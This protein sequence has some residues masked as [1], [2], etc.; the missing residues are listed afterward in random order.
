MKPCIE[1]NVLEELLT[2]LKLEKIEENIFRG[3]S[4]DLGFGGLF[5][6]QVLGQ[7][8]SAAYQ[9]VPSDRKAHSLHAYFLR[10]GNAA[11]PI[12][13]DVDCIRDGQSFTTRRVVAIQ[14]GRA[15]F[16]MS[17]SF[18]LDESGFEHQNDAPEVPGPNGIPSEME[19]A[20]MVAD[21]IP[22]AIRE[23]I[24]CAKPIEIRPIN[25]L[26][27]F[28]PEKR[29]PLRYT[30]F[31]TIDQL[32][33]D[34]AIH[35]YLLAYASDF[36]LVVTSLY[37]HGHS[38]WEPGMKIASLD[39]AMWFHRDFRIDDWMLYAMKSPNACKARGFNNGKI[40]TRQGKLVASV[41]QEG[42]IRYRDVKK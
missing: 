4:Q 17:A 5:G 16:N 36:G 30:W 21:K 28:A 40:Y 35:Q 3:Q 8:L 15:I 41:C 20:E 25:P 32:P 37:P 7:A 27:P 10:M 22:D 23:K 1:G 12:V 18:Q 14:K 31:K 9:T 24:L 42:L 19:L 34:P 29:E 2:L 13:Y 33:D 6:G 26:N 11:K 39:H 38:F